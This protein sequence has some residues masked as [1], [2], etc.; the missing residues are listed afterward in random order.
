[1]SELEQALADLAQEIEF[2]PTADLA[3]LVAS[4]LERRRHRLR[5][6]LVVA[7]LLAVLGATLAVPSARTALLQFFHLRGVTVER[8]ET[9]P[10]GR[11]RALGG[12]LGRLLPLAEAERRTGVDLLLPPGEHPRRARVEG[13]LVSVVLGRGDEPVVLS[14][15]RATGID[16]LKKVAGPTTRVAP[17][18][19]DGSPGL[20]IEGAP[21]ELLFVSDGEGVLSVPVRVRGNVLL[22]QRGDL[23]LRL[24]GRLSRDDALRVARSMR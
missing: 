24:Q 6:A 11:E 22:W 20:W 13:S 12:S 7:A 23:T 18:R 9:L 5:L 1:M 19:V 15:F 14:E 16:L 10:P 17:V 3:A 21:H 2:P 8:V 4:R